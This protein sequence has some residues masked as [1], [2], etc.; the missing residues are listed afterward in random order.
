MKI[1]PWF[2]TMMLISAGC[3][4]VV[5]EGG[6]SPPSGPCDA[7]RAQSLIGRTGTG[8]IAADALS[9]TGAKSLRWIQPGQAV[10]MDFR[11]DRLNIE[12]D[13]GNRIL[14]ITCG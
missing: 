12:L 14:R 13:A 2:A 11:P 5:P 8:Q 4:Q 10:T 3:V 1:S 9:R 7:S 6:S